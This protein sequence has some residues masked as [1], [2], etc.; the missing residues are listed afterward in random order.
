M[1]MLNKLIS[2]PDAVKNIKDMLGNVSEKNG[3]DNTGVNDSN[4]LPDSMPFIYE[5]LSNQQNSEML[6][7]INKVYSGYSNN[8]TPGLKLLDALKPF[9]SSKRIENFEKIRKAVKISNAFSELKK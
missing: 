2:D 1:D 7:K 6:H 3:T 5:F 4:G 8:L 9:L